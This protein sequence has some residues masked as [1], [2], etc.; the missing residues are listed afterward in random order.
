MMERWL[1]YAFL[2]AICAAFVSIFGKIGL[3]DIDS[4][5]ATAIRAAIM[6]VFLIGVAVV[7]GHISAVPLSWAIPKPC[8]A[9]H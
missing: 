5:A 7:Q 8:S 3:S 1:I 2:S 6:A 9:S 4:T